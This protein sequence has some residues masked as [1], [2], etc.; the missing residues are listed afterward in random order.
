MDSRREHIKEVAEAS[1]K[2]LETD[3]I[4]LFYQ[5]RLDPNVPNEDVAGTTLSPP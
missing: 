1:L 3:R 5:H 4:D 2:R